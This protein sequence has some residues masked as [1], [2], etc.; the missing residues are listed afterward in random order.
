MTSTLDQLPPDPVLQRRIAIQETASRSLRRRTLT[1]RTMLVLCAVALLVALT[2]LFALLWSLVDNGLRW[3]SVQFFTTEPGVPSIFQPNDVGGFANAIIGTFLIVVMAAIV[4]VPIG[5]VAG[6][7]VTESTS[8]F[9]TTLRT[10]AELMT[11]LPSVLLGVFAYELIVVGG[12]RW[13]IDFPRVGFSAFAGAVA[14][15]VLMVPIIMKA[16]EASLRSVPVAVREAGLALGARKGA[17]ARRVILPTALPGLIT[18]ILLSIARA[19]GETAPLLW[20]IGA[21][22]YNPLTWNPKHP[23]AAITLLIY[24]AANSPYPAERE[25]AW[26][27]ALFLVVMVLVLNVACRLIASFIQRERRS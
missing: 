6:L 4:A 13:G 24:Q 19:I 9:A 16:S 22:I 11:G 14:L 18:A 23:I 1:S 7:F 25:S 21:S 10:V 15:A 5:I 17:V 26:G 27:V 12:E 20:C 2:P 3:W 8:K